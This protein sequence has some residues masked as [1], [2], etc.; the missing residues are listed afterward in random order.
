ME[1]GERDLRAEVDRDLER[2]QDGRKLE[3]AGTEFP[4]RSL[5]AAIVF[6]AV[7]A[8]VLLLCFLLLGPVGIAIGFFV[9]AAA[10]LLAV[11]GY[12]GLTTRG[13]APGDH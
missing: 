6:V 5:T 13:D 9:G 10:G 1:G 2:L 8:L 7:D 4:L 3:A 12:A 11:K